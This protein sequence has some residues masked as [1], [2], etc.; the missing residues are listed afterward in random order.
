MAPAGVMPFLSSPWNI[1]TII[2]NNISIIVNAFILIDS[3][4]RMI[5]AVSN[6]TNCRKI[7][8]IHSPHNVC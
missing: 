6:G 2:N 8:V 5:N 3:E 4:A 1:F 7:K